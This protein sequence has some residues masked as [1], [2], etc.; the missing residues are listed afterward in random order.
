[1]F[2]RL[3]Q[4]GKILIPMRGPD[5]H[6]LLPPSSIQTT[7]NPRP[8]QDMADKRHGTTLTRLNI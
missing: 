2:S 1:M 3:S 8:A 7:V 5:V 6:N 4:T